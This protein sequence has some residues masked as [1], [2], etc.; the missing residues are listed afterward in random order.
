MY[1]YVKDGKRISLDEPLYFFEWKYGDGHVTFGMHGTL[2]E[3][4][5][6]CSIDNRV[7]Q[8]ITKRQIP[9][10]DS[11]LSDRQR[12]LQKVALA[13]AQ[14]LGCGGNLTPAEALNNTRK[15]LQEILAEG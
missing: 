4:M 1:I 3:Y 12:L 7:R 15:I 8:L 13:E 6:E 11:E 9:V 10:E 2:T 5:R 14:H